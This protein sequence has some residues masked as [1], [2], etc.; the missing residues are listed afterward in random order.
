MVSAVQL[1]LLL[2]ALLALTFDIQPVKAEP[3]TIVVPDDY[4]TIQ[5]AINA[6]SRWDTIYVKSGTYYENVVVNKI[7]F[8][9]GED[10]DT[11]IIDGSN[12]GN[13]I[14]V[15]ADNVTIR[16]FTLRKSG[17]GNSGILL[18]KVENCIISMNSITENWYGMEL[19][20]SANNSIM[21]NS[22]SNNTQ[23][24][25]LRDSSANNTIYSN[26]ITNNGVG[27]FIFFEIEITWS[28]SLEDTLNMHNSI[29]HNNFINNTNQVSTPKELLNKWDDGYPSGGNYWSDYEGDDFYRGPNQDKHGR[30]GIGDRPYVIDK[31]NHDNY[32]LMHPWGSRQATIWTRI[33]NILFTKPQMKS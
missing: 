26:E 24:I 31:N 25:Y 11:T 20:F 8:L 7:V 16:R 22:I 6:A 4:P 12:A 1:T 33:R 13:V 27:L 3:K 23:G 29:Y 10:Q 32:P 19:G 21:E 18:N 5:Q 15:T 9:V 17:F 2:V 28:V 14:E 30:D